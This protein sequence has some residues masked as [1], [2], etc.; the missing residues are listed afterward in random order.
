M[1]GEV[2]FRLVGPSGDEWSFGPDDAPTVIRGSG[3]EL[4]HVASRRV[5]PADTSLVGE[6]PDADDVLAVIRTWA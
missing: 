5:S 2:A 3:V 4:C 1:T 6:G